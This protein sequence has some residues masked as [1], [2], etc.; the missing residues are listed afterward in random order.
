M[1]F[2]KDAKAKVSSSTSTSGMAQHTEILNPKTK[3]EFQENFVELVPFST[4]MLIYNYF[5]Y[6]VW[7]ILSVA[8]IGGILYVPAWAA[9]LCFSISYMRQ[10][11]WFIL[12][13]LDF[14]LLFIVHH[15]DLINK[16]EENKVCNHLG[17]MAWRH[18]YHKT[19]TFTE[20]WLRYRISYCDYRMWLMIAVECVMEYSLGFQYWWLNGMFQHTW[21]HIE[22]ITHEW[23]HV[24]LDKRAT[25][26]RVP[27][28][29]WL[30]FFME[31]IGMI[32][33]VK[34]MGHHGH[35]ITNQLEVDDFF[36]MWVPSF[37]V[38]FAD[39]IWRTSL[40]QF[41][42]VEPMTAPIDHP[43]F[44]EENKKLYH[45]K[46]TSRNFKNYLISSMIGVAMCCTNYEKVFAVV[47]QACVSAG[48]F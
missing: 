1:V 45:Q 8:T 25:Y 16:P 13:H 35:E 4:G 18:H 38:R 40:K 44:S 31:W 6:T 14:H 2:R 47:S 30:W 41:K 34:H 5:L 21:T 46:L 36:D 7:C 39:N 29:G 32:S 23:Y 37:M 33:T 15:Y 42:L 20:F 12:I 9:L 26:F 28:V 43:M 17:F 19:N 27:P 3:A 11:M 10:S 48:I 22:A 24:P